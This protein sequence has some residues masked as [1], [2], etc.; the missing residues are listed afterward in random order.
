[1]GK[2][3]TAQLLNELSNAKNLNY[4]LDKNEGSFVDTP[5]RDYLREL[6]EGQERSKADIARRAGIST[7]YLY[8]LLSGER[9]PSRNRILSLSL[10]M[11]LDITRTQE[12]LRR[13]GFAPLY[14]RDRRDAVILYGLTHGQSVEEVD[15][16]LFTAGEKALS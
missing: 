10:A 6:I 13:C 9:T 12:L 3:T 5:A 2:K 14:A 8:Q 1:M 11:E 7:V 16:A 15:S 4:V